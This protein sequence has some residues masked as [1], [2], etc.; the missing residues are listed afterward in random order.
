MT[1]CQCI[2]SWASV[3]VKASHLLERVSHIEPHCCHLSCLSD[4]VNSSKGLLFESWVPRYLVPPQ[5]E[6]ELELTSEAP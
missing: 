5:G 4:S 1:C 2:K 6:D 3:F